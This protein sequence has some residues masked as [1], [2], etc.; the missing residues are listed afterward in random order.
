MVSNKDLQ[1]TN[2]RKIKGKIIEEAKIKLLMVKNMNL[3]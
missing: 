2:N 3:L 1:R